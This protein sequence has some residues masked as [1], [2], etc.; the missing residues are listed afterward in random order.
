MRTRRGASSRPKTI[1][2]TTILS[3]RG[4]A[5]VHARLG[6]MGFLWYPSPQVE[7]GIDGHLEV[8]D[9]TTGEVHN[10]IVQVQSK[11]TALPLGRPEEEEF[12]WTCTSRDLDY[13]LYGNAP[14]ILVYSRPDTGEAYW[15]SIR[16]YFATPELR[17]SKRIVFRKSKD[18]FD[19][20]ARDAIAKLA[21]PRER[22]VYFSVPPKTE[23]LW[24]NLLPITRF[25]ENVYVAESSLRTPAEVRA[26]L[27][28]ASSDAPNE[29]VLR[30]TQVLAFCDVRAQMW[31]K[32]CDPGVTE[33]FPVTEW[34]DSPD[35][36]RQRDFVALL[37]QTLRSQ[38]QR[39][40]VA[41]NKSQECYLFRAT[42]KLSPKVLPY[43][44]LKNNTSRTVF[45]A[46]PS[47]KDPSQI[48]YYRHSAFSGVFKRLD[49]MWYLEILP[50]YFFS[51][52]GVKRHP[53]YESKL[54]GIKAQ[55]RNDAVRNQVVMWAEVLKESQPSLFT[56]L[57][58]L[59]FGELTTFEVH[60][61][62]D[63]NLWLTKDDV[64]ESTALGDGDDDGP[65]FEE[66]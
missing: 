37:N 6:D 53:F 35:P 47:K 26:A 52:D 38:L 61:G 24:S 19:A 40:H 64:V 31:S 55:E 5:L 54:K 2:S 42:P 46:Y 29:W 58:M 49:G 20:S 41:F 43:R 25:P 12:E 66:D 14:V 15:V 13:W 16:D 30:G 60:G 8:R 56:S 17:R 65:L 28:A 48:A 50:T 45:C 57:A 10:A 27:R 9:P 11:A 1:L 4:I 22:G 59:R 21:L 18:R 3:E 51:E 33:P 23:T 7:A 34:S 63:D 62:V 32:V 44:S 36:D 39:L